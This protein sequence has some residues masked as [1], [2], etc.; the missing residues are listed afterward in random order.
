MR[1]TGLPAY[2]VYCRGISGHLS[3][4][5]SSGVSLDR[6]A[7][8]L[9]LARNLKAWMSL[10]AEEFVGDVDP[11]IGFGRWRWAM[12]DA[13]QG[14]KTLTSRFCSFRLLDCTRTSFLVPEANGA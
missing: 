5:H 10:Q 3:Y 12:G 2:F 9:A 14:W 4:R 13:E 8:S 6:V 1:E 7:V 11:A